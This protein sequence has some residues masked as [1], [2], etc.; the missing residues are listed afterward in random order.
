MESLHLSMRITWILGLAAM[1][2]FTFGCISDQNKSEIASEPSKMQLGDSITQILQQ[3][4]LAEVQH[5]IKSGGTEG[6]ISYCNEMALHLTD[7][8]AKKNDVSIRRISSKNRNPM[9]GPV[10]NEELLLVEMEKL[11][12]YDT[13]I[14]DRVGSTYYKAIHLGMSACL[15]CH[16]IPM[17][18]I[19]KT[20][21]AIIDSLYPNDLA[22]NYSLGDFRGVWKVQF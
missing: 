11:N 5:Q 22:R 20:T 14:K 6:A 18:D 19:S 17:N 21:L 3:A 1:L 10:A 16:G 15:T 13:L 9:N 8:L 12:R 4:L 2:W 7:S